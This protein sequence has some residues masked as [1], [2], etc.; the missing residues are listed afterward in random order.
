MYG[1]GLDAMGETMEKIPEKEVAT[2]FAKVGVAG[3]PLRHLPFSSL[4]KSKFHEY[5]VLRHWPKL[6]CFEKLAGWSS[7][8]WRHP[9]SFQKHGWREVLS[10]L[11]KF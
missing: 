11:S 6:K 7:L 3:N 1:E 10:M 8:K 9:I 4:R 5:G 2:L